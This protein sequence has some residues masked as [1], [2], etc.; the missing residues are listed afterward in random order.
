M[1]ISKCSEN[2]DIALEDLQPFVGAFGISTFLSTNVP[3]F[4]LLSMGGAGLSKAHSE[5]GG[6]CSKALMMLGGMCGVE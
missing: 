1:Y 2:G 6:I 5:L 4:T 3:Y